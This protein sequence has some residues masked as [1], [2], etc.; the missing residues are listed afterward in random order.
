M[1]YLSQ[2]CP[3]AQFTH[4]KK[5]KSFTLLEV[6]VPYTKMILKLIFTQTCFEAIRKLCEKKMQDF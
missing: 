4:D 5:Q 1:Q 6:S 3:P 2:V